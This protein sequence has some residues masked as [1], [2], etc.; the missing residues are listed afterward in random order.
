[1]KEYSIN[2]EEKKQFFFNY[3]TVEETYL[4]LIKNYSFCDGLLTKEK[5]Q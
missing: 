1:M 5:I 2:T 4:D 3:K